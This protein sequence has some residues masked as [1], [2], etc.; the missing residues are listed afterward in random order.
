MGAEGKKNKRAHNTNKPAGSKSPA[1]QACGSMPRGPRRRNGTARYSREAQPPCRLGRVESAQAPTSSMSFHSRRFGPWVKQQNRKVH[2]LPATRSNCPRRGDLQIARSRAA[3]E[4]EPQLLFRLHRNGRS[5]DRPY[6]STR[7]NGMRRGG[8]RVQ[9]IGARR[10]LG[11]AIPPCPVCEP[12]ARRGRSRRWTGRDGRD[13][14][15]PD[16]ARWCRPRRR[17]ASWWRRRRSR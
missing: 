9:L 1:C 5:G 12:A 4:H 15:S 17:C 8:R 6:G 11:S 13:C 3:R 7:A 10:S 2:P 16:A 14:C